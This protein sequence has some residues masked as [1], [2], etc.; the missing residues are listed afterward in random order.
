[1]GIITRQCELTINGI[2]ADSAKNKEKTL[3]KYNNLFY[4]IDKNPE[5]KGAAPED[6][7]Y[8]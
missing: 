8:E 1:M 3:I 2:I 4:F 7:I 6:L 5:I